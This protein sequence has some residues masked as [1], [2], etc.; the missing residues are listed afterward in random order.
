MISYEQAQ[1]AGKIFLLLEITSLNWV[2]LKNYENH[3]QQYTNLKIIPK[4]NNFVVSYPT[5]IVSL[6]K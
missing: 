6:F 5:A 2:L 1:K 3:N 4:E